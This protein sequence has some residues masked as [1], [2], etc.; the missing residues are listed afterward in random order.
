MWPLRR[1]SAC[2]NSAVNKACSRRLNS[3][4]SSVSQAI[5]ADFIHDLGGDLLDRT[6]GGRQPGNAFHAHQTLG[7]GDFLATLV[8]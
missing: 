2:L 7:V 4:Q 3:P 5:Q 1:R 6:C 8:Q